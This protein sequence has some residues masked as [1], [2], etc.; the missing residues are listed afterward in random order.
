M[1]AKTIITVVVPSDI[2]VMQIGVQ[3]VWLIPTPSMI[4][5]VLVGRTM[6]AHF[7]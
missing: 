3:V 6:L 4:E 1:L 2:I 5:Q 7:I